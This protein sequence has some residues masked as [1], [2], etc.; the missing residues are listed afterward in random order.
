MARLNFVA[1]YVEQGVLIAYSI[2]IPSGNIG[3]FLPSVH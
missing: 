2:L 3:I 1:F